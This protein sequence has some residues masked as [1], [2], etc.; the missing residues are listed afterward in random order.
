MEREAVIQFMNEK[1]PHL[2]TGA[3]LNGHSYGDLLR[4]LTGH[5]DHLSAGSTPITFDK[6]FAED[7]GFVGQ[8]PKRW[9]R[10]RKD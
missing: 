6:M 9:R 4:R 5:L 2:L 3:N 8:F 1:F 7:P 10:W